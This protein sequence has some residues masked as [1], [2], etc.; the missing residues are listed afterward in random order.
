M[1]KLSYYNDQQL[2]SRQA[3]YNG[4]VG[5]RGLGKTYGFKKRAI[6][7]AIKR[8]REFI[9]LRRY[10]EELN[11]AR[12]T[13][14]ADVGHEFPD[15]DFRTFGKYAQ[16][17]PVLKRID[18]ET[19][20]ERVKREKTRSW[21]TIG[22]FVALST[23]QQKK[24]TSYPNVH[25]ILFDEFIIEKGN[26]RYIQNEVTAFNNFYST[27]DRWNDRV[28]VFFLA[29]SVNI[30][31][32][33]FLEWEIRP[34]EESEFVT[35]G[36]GFI[37]FHFP[38]SAKFQSEVF[39]TRFG[40]FIKTTSPEYADYA[41]GNT[42][43]DNHDLLLDL[44]DYRATHLFNLETKHGVFSVWQARN[45]EASLLGSRT[46]YYVQNK[47]P[48]SGLMFTL[49]ADKMDENKMLMTYRDKP[50]EALRTAFR[51][52]NVMFDTPPTRNTFIDIF[53][54]R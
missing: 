10:K 23:A 12:S 5:A 26:V 24:G 37:C 30:M 9:L 39:Q 31:N 17:S 3:T 42:F 13:F 6:R 53:E 27:V 44:K 1:A 28:K 50:L 2:L 36:D 25:T 7:D 54:R 49:L 41:V 48:K 20:A 46:T 43:S 15:H 40:K 45:A 19:E 4:V 22:Y 18:G 35:R 32:P 11:E 14:F 47:L 51:T 38:D 21:T 52:G 34:D 16:S 29:N 33:Y 8:G